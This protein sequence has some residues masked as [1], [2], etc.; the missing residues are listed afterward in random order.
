MPLTVA[1]ARVST[2]SGEQLS[3]LN[4]QIAWLES[5]GPDV[6]LSDVESGRVVS[7]ANYQQLRAMVERGQVETVIATSLSRLGR[8]AAES[9]AFVALCDAQ[10]VVVTTRDEG[11][12][13]MATPES[14]LLTRMR[15]SLNQGESM[16]ISQRVRRGLEQGRAMRK[17]MRKPCWGYRLRAD[18]LAM[19]P[20]PEA[21]L[22]AQ[23][24]I[25]ALQAGGWRMLPA[26]Q[27]HRETVPFR[28]VR[29][30]RAWLLNPTLRGG[31]GYQQGKNHTFA[32]VHWDQHP[33]LLTHAQ[34]AEF[35]RQ[36]QQNRRMWGSNVTRK[37][38]I[39]TSLVVCA[40]C[41]CVMKYVSGR[42]IPSLRCYGDL[43]SQVYK[44]TREAVIVQFAIDAIRE[45]AAERLAA[46][47]IQGEPPEARELRRQ[48]ESLQKL[49]DPDLAPVIAAKHQRLEQV[50][51]RPAVDGELARKLADPAWWDE[52]REDEVAA[53][54]RAVV[55]RI[56]VARQEPIAVD[57]RL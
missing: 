55:S 29:G 52:A 2:A 5:Q 1:Y 8:D 23:R 47:A 12:L 16:R 56:V 33:A 18:R 35:E 49:A 20:D 19:E 10:G 24:F 7:R 53:M 44:G 41:G 11:P 30:V 54:L 31:I 6:L 39:L 21:W 50:L 13:S 43:C 40:E 14:L 25:D 45:H 3:A 51:T 36:V 46:L 32:E 38:R 34:F 37:P 28:S 17:P 4:A 22:Q 42:T 9:D 27:A 15:G 26:L 57:L 48:I